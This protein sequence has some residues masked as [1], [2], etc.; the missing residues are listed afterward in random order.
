MLPIG[1][2]HSI[3]DFKF[4]SG[5]TNYVTLSY[6]NTI[7]GWDQKTNKLLYSAE[8]GNAFILSPDSKFFASVSENNKNFIIKSTQNGLEAYRITDTEADFK[9]LAFSGD[10]RLLAALSQRA[11]SNF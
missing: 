2:T 1:H 6:D 3:T 7:K 11:D 8:K 9:V 5:A 10:G 4:N